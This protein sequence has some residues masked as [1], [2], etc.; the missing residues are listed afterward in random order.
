MSKR[1]N[2]RLVKIHR[3][4]EVADIAKL[5]GIH[6]N[7]VRTWIKQGLPV[8]DNRRPQLI[9]GSA[10][11]DFLQA[12]RT[13]HK[14]PCQPGELYCLR[15]RQPRKPAGDMADFAPI[16][17]KVGKFTAICPV[18]ECLMHKRIG[19]AEFVEIRTQLGITFTQALQ[20]IGDST[21]P[22]VNSDLKEVMTP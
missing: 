16:T 3:S 15:C 18:C 13:K 20:R 5:F 1:P 10:L 2:P 11:R 21:Q 9:T 8:C 19:M 6:R 7:T 22:I 17:P 4:Y 14:S 12:K